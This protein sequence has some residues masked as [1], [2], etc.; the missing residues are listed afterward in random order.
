MYI[1]IFSH[2]LL[3]N[4]IFVHIFSIHYCIPKYDLPIGYV[5]ITLLQVTQQ[6]QLYT[7]FLE[8]K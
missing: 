8:K 6:P 4:L 2:T 1:Y 5:T 7:S 3:S